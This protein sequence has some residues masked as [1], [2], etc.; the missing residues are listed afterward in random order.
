M[1]DNAQ[2]QTHEFQTEVSQ[3]LQLM[4]HS[5]YSNKEIFLRE[6]VSNASDACDK[7]RFEALSN[8]DLYE[9]QS[10]LAIKVD[11][12]KDAG[13]V[14]I[15]D[16]GIGM[17]K[18]DII[19]NIGTI[20]K[21]GTKQFFESLT[22][23]QANDANLIGQFGVGFYSAFI[24]A[25]KVTVTSRRAG[26]A[27]DQAVVWESKGDGSFTTSAASKE[28]RGTEIVLHLK[29]DETEFADS[30]RLRTTISRYSD[31]IALPVMMLKEPEAPA[32]GEE[33]KE[34]APEWEQIN[35]ASALWARSKS[36][37]KDEEYQE[38]YKSLSHDFKDA[39]T[40]SH[41][42]VEGKY[43]YTS[44]FYIPSQAPFDL[45]DREQK[46]G[47]KLYVQRVFIMDE[48]EKILPKY[49]RFVKGLVDSNDLPLNVSREILQS[50]KVIDSIRSG[51]VKKILGLIEKMSKNEAEKFAEFWKSFGQVMKE[52]VAED[53]PN[54]SQIGGLLRFA[55][56]HAESL[57][58]N[59]EQTV[60]LESYIERMAEK[61]DKIYYVTAD[62]W[63]AAKNSPHLEVFKKRGIE[64]LLMTDR[65]D[66]WMM[67]R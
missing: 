17:N 44:L 6:L 21:S 30:W 67:R 32:E 37:I 3:L 2:T 7:L 45:F 14:T 10:D 58:K 33:P 16:N 25:E 63:A 18:D 36:E 13:T 47:I 53:M 11:F 15:S 31:H 39:S 28:E 49:L 19:Q 4:I 50:N 66:E 24:V 29:D 40:W 57:D 52:G 1:T 5:L 38:F 22:G 54:Q 55:S 62:T 56:T 65:V 48:A 34:Q 8:G 43:E 42:R 61:Q 20:A 60:G 9:G 23:D 12:D 35:K 59:G 64:V 41:N 46:G 27:A 26:D 51:S